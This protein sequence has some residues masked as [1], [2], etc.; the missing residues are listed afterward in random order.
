MSKCQ[1]IVNAL[2]ARPLRFNEIKK[3]FTEITQKALTQHSS[4][5]NGTAWC[6]ALSSAPHR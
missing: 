3:F 5:W 2:S 4:A 6:S 1:L